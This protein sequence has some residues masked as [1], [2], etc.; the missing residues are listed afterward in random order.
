MIEEGNTAI[1]NIR[2]A[3]KALDEGKT[4]EKLKVL[5]TAT[6]KIDLLVS[7]DPNLQLAPVDEAAN[8]INEEKIQQARHT[9]KN[10]ASEIEITTTSISLIN[11]NFVF[12]F[13]L[14]LS[15]DIL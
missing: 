9:F 13:V 2:G 3:L 12:Y 6:G 1:S 10:L 14:L 7:R 4:E 11:L 5:A 8:A 15:E